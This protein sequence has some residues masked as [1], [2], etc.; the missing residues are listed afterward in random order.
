MRVLL[1][2]AFKT[3]YRAYYYHYSSGP[4]SP[5]A[6]W[7]PK[8]IGATT[9][10]RHIGRI[11]RDLGWSSQKPERRHIAQRGKNHS[12]VDRVALFN[13]TKYGRHRI[14]GFRSSTQPTMLNGLGNHNNKPQI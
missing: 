2:F 9:A 7:K 4:S 12:L 3:R 14:V 8:G 11:L 5:A 1:F 10:A 6:Q 13:P